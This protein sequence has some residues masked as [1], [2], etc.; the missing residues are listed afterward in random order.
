MNTVQ[1][2]VEIKRTENLYD[3][4][5]RNGDE[6]FNS[7]FI[8]NDDLLMGLHTQELICHDTGGDEY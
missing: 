1:T 6:I 5:S 3:H 2:K 4:H 8:F 7:M